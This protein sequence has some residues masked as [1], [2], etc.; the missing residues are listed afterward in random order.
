MENEQ[1]VA[2]RVLISGQVQGVGYRL[3]TRSQAQQRKIKGWVRNLADG[4]VEAVFE[5]NANAVERMRQWCYTGPPAA[6]VDNVTF[7]KVQWENLQE[8]AIRY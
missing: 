3:A 1:L 2:I 8:F 5:G 7:E 6:V 4:R